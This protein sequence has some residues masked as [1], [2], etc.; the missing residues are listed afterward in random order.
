MKG[1]FEV[2]CARRGRKI[3][4]EA[5]NDGPERVCRENIIRRLLLTQNFNALLGV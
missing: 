1:I 2:F 4:S 5:R 3:T